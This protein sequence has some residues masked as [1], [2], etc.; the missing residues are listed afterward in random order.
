[1]L[2][3]YDEKEVLRYLGYRGKPADDGVKSLIDKAYSELCRTVQPRYIYKEYNFEKG[4]DGIMVNGIGFHSKKLAY[5]LKNSRTVIL[6]AA[7]LGAGADMLVRRYS[8]SDTA[9]AA[10]TQAVASA[11]TENLCD[12]SCDELSRLSGSELTPRFSPG[13]G[14]L[15]LSSQQDFFRLLD[16]SKHL[17]V[18]L[19]DTFLMTPSKSVTAFIGKLG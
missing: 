7:T 4:E 15:P 19:S 3:K 8:L 14:D 10:V 5:H 9:L 18:T 11:L 17:G 1:M 12:N 6:F 16:I 13:Y 2:L